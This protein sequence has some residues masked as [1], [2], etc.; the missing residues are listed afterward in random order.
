M[1]DAATASVVERGRSDLFLTTGH[2]YLTSYYNLQDWQDAILITQQHKECVMPRKPRLYLPNIPAHVVQRGNNRDACFFSDQDYLY[3]LEVL[4]EGCRRYDVQLHAYCLMTN[5]V[6]LLMTQVHEDR[7]I[8]QVMQHIGRMYVAYINKTYRRSGTLWEGRHKASL[9]DADTYLLTCMRYIELNPV[10]ADMVMTPEQYRWSSYRY[11]AWGEK[12]N[13]II[14]HVNYL[15][16]GN[17]VEARQQAY[18]ELFKYQVSDADIH[19]IREA[20]NYNFPLG[21]ERFREQVEGMLGRSVGY[22]VRGRPCIEEEYMDYG[23]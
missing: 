18:R 1:D 20:L 8:S 14:D 10:V 22:K 15:E 13:R 9:V 19:E 21:N 4:A 17:D 6:H 3:Y 2:L 16:L 7:G 23:Y 5:H 11:Y 12:N